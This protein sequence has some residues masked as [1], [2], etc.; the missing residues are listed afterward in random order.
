MLLQESKLN[1]THI[2]SI[3]VFSFSC[4]EHG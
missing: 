1:S 2:L 3:R 4:W